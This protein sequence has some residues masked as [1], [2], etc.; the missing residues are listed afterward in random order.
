MLKNKSFIFLGSSVTYGNNGY[1]FVEMLAERNALTYIKEAVSG[2]ALAHTDDGSY[3]ARLT[4]RVDKDFKADAFLCQ[5]STNDA[6][7]NLPHGSISE[8]FEYSDFDKSTTCGAIEYIIKYVKDTWSC[9]VFFYTGTRF[10][11]E[12]Y[13]RMVSDLLVIAKKWDITVIDL[14]NEEYLN[15]ITPEQTKR[16]MKDPVHPTTEGYMEHWLPFIEGKLCE[17]L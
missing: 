13:A 7:R 15:N 3:V 10:N 2:T 4:S 6:G 12:R 5:L 11:S 17:K 1:S 16:W 8:G 9:P 14:W